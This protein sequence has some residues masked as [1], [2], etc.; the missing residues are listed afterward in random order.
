M[1]TPKPRRAI[2]V[3]F[4]GL[5]LV[6]WSAFVRIAPSFA[7]VPVDE[8]H[9]TFGGPTSVTLDWR[10]TAQDVQYG[11]TTAY[12]SAATGVA[13]AW[14]PISS[15]GPFWQ[16]Q[17]TGLAASTTYHY[18]IGGGPDHTFHTPPTGDFRFDAIGDIGDTT[19]FSHLADTF[20]AIASD[21]PSFVLM[22]GDLTYANASNATQAVVDQ[23]FNDVMAF[24]TSAA[25]LPAWGNHEWE[26][27]ALDDLR[28]YKGRLLFPNAAQSPGSPAVSDG[29]NDW[30]WFDAGGVRFIAYPEPY[31]SATWPDWQAHASDLMAAAQTDPGVH[32]I[33]TYGHRPAYSTGFHPGDATLAGIL[34]GLGTT[35]SKYVLNINGHSHDYE[36]FKPIDGVTHVTVGTPASEETPWG[37]TDPNTAFRAFHLAHL[38]VDVD[39]AG[40][41]IQAVC[42]DAASRDDITCAPGSVIDEYTIGTPPPEPPVTAFY[43]DKTN[44]QC[45][46]LGPGNVATPYCTIAKGTSRLLPGQTLY[47]GNGTY[48][49]Q[50]SP[51]SG[52][53]TAPVTVT[54]LAGTSPTVT[55]TATQ[56]HGIYLANRSYVTVSG[57]TV[58]SAV[59]DGVYVTG[60]TNVTLSGLRVTGSGQPT[61]TGYAKGFKVVGTTNSTISGNTAD[62]NTDSGIYLAQGSTGNLIVGNTTY[63][64]ARQYTRAAPG[65]DLR[66]GGNTVRGNLTHDNEDSGIQLYTGSDGSLVV[67]NVSYRNGDHG[68]DDFQATNQRIIS[69]S[70]YRN[71]TAGINLEGGSTGG[72]VEN[73]ISVDNGLGSP[74]TVGDIRVDSTSQ[75]GT[76]VNA[77]LVYLHAPGAYYVWGTTNYGS[78]SAFTSATGQESQ[79]R[80]ADPR[81]ASPDTG[82]FTL[83]AGSPPID[84]ADSTVSGEQ[85]AD[86]AGTARYDDP[87]VANGFN[88]YD[89]RGAYEAPAGTTDRSP[90]AMLRVTPSSG[91]SPLSVT[92]DAGQS[93]DTDGTGIASYAF[94]FGD[95]TGAGP[96]SAPTAGHTY[97]NS[98]TYTLAVSV[99]DTAGLT[100]TTAVQVT[101]GL[102][103]NLVTN[104]TF[105]TDLSGWAPLAGCNLTRVAAGHNEGWAADLNNPLSSAQTCTLNDSPNWALKSVAG[106]YTATAWVNT[107][108]VG[109]QIKLRIREYSGTTLVGT[110]T[111]TINPTGDWQQMTLQYQVVSPGSTLD[112]NVYETNQPGGSDLLIDD[113][114]LKSG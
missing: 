79:G 41:R 5:A 4:F 100:L 31:T 21:Q 19:H 65:I 87:S 102:A 83:T 30:G 14:T 55:G 97:P 85:P 22:D 13:P 106:T 58:T 96:Q 53:A 66:S 11:L 108:A 112:L 78:L 15:P 84:S 75:T 25:Y 43:T 61:S 2:A 17:I 34:N 6:L 16:A 101:V 71:A 64:N 114:T 47:V 28:N 54:A 1:S 9:Y 91:T 39:A 36:R 63:S 27:P 110:G 44:A 56:T 20:S 33:V 99:T 103:G 107:Q 57:L 81:W 51:P 29:G 86:I 69:N 60:G 82:A 59:S 94:D 49:E 32:Y 48:A 104:S 46:D 77:N 74:R 24:G 50:V 88:G 3:V 8:V 70:V 95:G 89:D 62:H 35:Y 45:S 18:S 23:H 73:N 105:E 93:T 26:S 10:G 92:A 111:A 38:R 68:I 40:M 80:Q 12:N 42:D 72:L 67:N 52:T 7:D 109:G 76:V 90:D 98:G 113:V 37:S